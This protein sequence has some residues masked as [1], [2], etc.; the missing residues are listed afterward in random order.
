MIGET[1]PE[2]LKSVKSTATTRPLEHRIPTQLEQTDVGDDE[3]FQLLKA[4]SEN[5]KPC[6]SVSK[7]WKSLTKEEA[8]Q[9]IIDPRTGKSD[10]KI[11]GTTMF[12]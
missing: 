1:E 2:R 12:G 8:K 6:L 4:G 9:G 3:E 5:L 11:K 7:T 10:K